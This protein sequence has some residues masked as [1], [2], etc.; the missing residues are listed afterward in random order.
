MI[1]YVV[2]HYGQVVASFTDKHEA[3]K[4]ARKLKRDYFDSSVQVKQLHLTE[5]A[6]T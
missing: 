6:T 3:W 4:K 2:L 5:S 1:T